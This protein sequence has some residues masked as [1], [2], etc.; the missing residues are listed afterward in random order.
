M[1]PSSRPCGCALV[2]SWPSI[3]PTVRLTLRIGKR[4]VTAAPWSMASRAAAMSWWSRAFS[5]P[6]S[7]ATV[8]CVPEPSGLRTSARIGLRSRPAAFQWLI[9]LAVSR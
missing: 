4:A 2:T 1:V 6:W 3:V 9:A 7:W 5:R 8:W